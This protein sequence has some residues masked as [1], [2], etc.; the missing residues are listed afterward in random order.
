MV[1]SSPITVREQ[2]VQQ[3]EATRQSRWLLDH[4]PS[5][6][7]LQD[8]IAAALSSIARGG[9][10]SESVFVTNLFEHFPLK[11]ARASSSSIEAGRVRVNFAGQMDLRMSRLTGSPVRFENTPFMREWSAARDSAKNILAE[12]RAAQAGQQ[13]K[14][15]RASTTARLLGAAKAGTGAVKS[16]ANG[17]KLRL[18]KKKSKK[19]VQP[20]R[21]RAAP[22]RADL[23]PAP[24]APHILVPARGSID[25]SIDTS[26]AS[27]A[28]KIAWGP[29]K[30]DFAMSI[31]VKV[32]DKDEPFFT[33]AGLWEGKSFI[34]EK[35]PTDEEAANAVLV[36]EEKTRRKAQRLG[37]AQCICYC[38]IN[39]QLGGLGFGMVGVAES[40]TRVLAISDTNV[41]VEVPEALAE[42]FADRDCNITELF[43]EKMGERL[44]ANTF[45]SNSGWNRR[46]DIQP[47][48][49][50]LEAVRR[51]RGFWT[52]C[53]ELVPD[54]IGPEGP[55]PFCAH[56]DLPIE[57][58]DNMPVDCARSA[59]VY[60]L[61]RLLRNRA[62]GE[63][64]E[65]RPRQAFVPSDA[66]E[67]GPDD[68][69]SEL[70][71][72]DGGEAAYHELATGKQRL[73]A[74]TTK[75]MDELQA[76]WPPC[77]NAG[78]RTL[79]CFKSPDEAYT[80]L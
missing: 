53:L 15:K 58:F 60:R 25:S 19:A 18:L 16:K 33:I 76:L 27:T 80:A 7:T 24:G 42:Q 67:L 69:R 73:R 28:S 66:E 57:E 9:V 75:I 14:P 68:S 17:A 77:R 2:S 34:L 79:G 4:F 22:P 36:A 41:L 70:G 52:R 1:L 62:T 23:V 48:E 45:L 56:I 47:S 43:P 10:G 20:A 49:I 78:R 65:S 46:D 40:F 31:M 11:A 59:D 38:V 29:Y 55:S 63:P 8:D 51:F 35:I 44:L 54:L 32:P 72:D 26:L 74:V 50:D 37:L 6:E 71:E 12:R 3:E 61:Y 64:S 21:E 30:P 39:K 5:V 13:L